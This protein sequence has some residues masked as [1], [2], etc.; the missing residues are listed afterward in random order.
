MKKTR[1]ALAL[2][3]SIILCLSLGSVSLAADAPEADY[4]IVNPYADVIWSGY[5]AWGAYKGSLHSHSTYRD[6]DETL[7]TMV[8]EAYRQD[9]D[10]LA[11]SDHGITGTDWDKA[12]FMHPL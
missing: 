11:V 12:P 5:N 2:L 4:T 8:K 1:K 3:L 6:A 10:F 9:Y 7:A